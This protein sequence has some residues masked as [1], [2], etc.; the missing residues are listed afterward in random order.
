MEDG[1]RIGNFFGS[2]SSDEEH[3][4]IGIEIGV[5]DVPSMDELARAKTFAIVFKLSHFVFALGYILKEY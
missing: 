5:I 2:Y 3:N 4:S 1:F